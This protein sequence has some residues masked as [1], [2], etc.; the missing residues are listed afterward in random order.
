MKTTLLAVMVLVGSACAA[1]IGVIT[2]NRFTKEVPVGHW[3]TFRIKSWKH[4]VAYYDSTERVVERLNE[5]LEENDV[6]FEEHQ[7][8]TEGNKY[9]EIENASGFWSTIYLEPEED[10]GWSRVTVYTAP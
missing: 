8:D 3:Y 10:K 6:F 1:Q 7:T 5:I 4:T 9:W 2:M